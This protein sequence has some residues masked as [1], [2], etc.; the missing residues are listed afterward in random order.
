[1]K[2]PIL[3]LALLPAICFAQTRGAATFSNKITVT[4]G[5]NS[6]E[7]IYYALPPDIGWL[8]ARNNPDTTTAP[9]PP[10][11]VSWNGNGAVIIRC[12]SGQASGDSVRALIQVLDREGNVVDNDNLYLLATATTFVSLFDDT[13]AKNFSLSGLYDPCFGFLVTFTQGDLTGGNRVYDVTFNTQ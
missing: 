8:P 4:V 10:D 2:K 7:T 6:S 11:R 13:N 5:V 12:R 9:N 3:L 1:M